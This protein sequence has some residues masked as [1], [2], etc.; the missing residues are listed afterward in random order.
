M[1]FLRKQQYFLFR[2]LANIETENYAAIQSELSYLGL[3]IHW[4][5][6]KKKKTFINTVSYVW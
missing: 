3:W 5:D 6:D 4:K 1:Y 2:N